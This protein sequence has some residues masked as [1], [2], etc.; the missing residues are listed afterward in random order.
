MGPANVFIIHFK[1]VAYYANFFSHKAGA[2]FLDVLWLA[3]LHDP[4]EN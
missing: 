3:K 4:D 1:L 2:C